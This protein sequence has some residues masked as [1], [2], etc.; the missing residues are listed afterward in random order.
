MKIFLIDDD[1]NIRD[2][3]G[4]ILSSKG[5]SISEAADG[6]DALA[7]LRGGAR[8]DLVIVDMMMPRIDGQAVIEAMRGDP[9]LAAIP[10]IVLSGHQ[11]ACDQAARL[12]AA[13]CLVKPVELSDLLDTVARIAARAPAHPAP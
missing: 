6:L 9:S 11:S 8:P 1:A 7:Q 10:V 5:H 2:V 3:L 13:G 4:M 12:G